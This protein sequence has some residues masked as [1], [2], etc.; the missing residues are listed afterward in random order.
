MNRKQALDEQWKQCWVC[1]KNISETSSKIPSGEKII[2][3][4]RALAEPNNVAPARWTHK[5]NLVDKESGF[6]Q[7]LHIHQECF[8]EVAGEDFK[9]WDDE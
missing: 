3:F 8:L 1:K 6:Q 7:R 4:S 5:L 9:F 2:I